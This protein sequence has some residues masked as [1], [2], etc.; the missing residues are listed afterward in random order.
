MK[1]KVNDNYIEVIEG[2]NLLQAFIR[3][4]ISIPSICNGEGKCGK[5]KV[6]IIKNIADITEKEESLLST[7]EKKEGISFRY[8]NYRG[9]LGIGRFK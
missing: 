4:E 3:N 6:K 1:V 7:K 2:E 8:W 5:C 9:S